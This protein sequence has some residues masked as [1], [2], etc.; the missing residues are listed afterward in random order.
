MIGELT[1]RRSVERIQY[2]HLKILPAGFSRRFIEIVPIVG[3]EKLVNTAMGGTQ[4]RTVLLVF[5]ENILYRF[6]CRLTWALDK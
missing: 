5:R 2:Q 3:E 1:L 4:D 6:F